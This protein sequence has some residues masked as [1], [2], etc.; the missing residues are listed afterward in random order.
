MSRIDN[1]RPPERVAYLRHPV[2]NRVL[3]LVSSP[4]TEQFLRNLRYD[5]GYLPATREDYRAQEEARKTGTSVV[6][7]Q[8]GVAT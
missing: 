3:A 6:V 5:S 7:R 8:K 4:A 2:S 1:W